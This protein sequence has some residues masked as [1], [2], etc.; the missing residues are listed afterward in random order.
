MGV[1]GAPRLG[2]KAEFDVNNLLLGGR[3]IRGIVEGDSIPQT[4]IPQLVQLHLQGRFPFDRL[5]KFYSLEQINQAA[6]DSSNGI[7]LKP[8]LRL[9]H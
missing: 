2:T 6:E 4:F 8:I 1:V 3:T 9:S 7:T 5:V